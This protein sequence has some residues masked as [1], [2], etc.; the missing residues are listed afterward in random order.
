MQAV[1]YVGSVQVDPL[2]VVGH[3]QDLVLWG[4]VE[5]YRTDHLERAI[6][7]DRSLFEWGGNLQIRPIEELP[8]LRIVMQRKVEEPR[9]TL[10]ARRNSGVIRAVL[11]EVERRGP[12]GSRDLASTGSGRVTNYR[13]R[14]EAGLALYYLW[15][16][17]DL[18][19]AHR[20]RG[21]K[22][23]DLATRTYPRALREVP[24]EEAE[25]HL[26]FGTL[27]DL[28]LATA[29]EWLAYAHTRI[30]RS[31]LRL[32][33]KARVQRWR[34]DGRIL[35]TDVD[36]WK[37]R[38][39]YVAEAAPD[40][41]ALRD[42]RVPKSWTPCRTSTEEEVVFLSPLERVSGNGRAARLFD[43]EYVWEVYKPAKD[44]RWGY[45]TLP[46]L[47]GDR[48]TARIELKFDRGHQLL[49]VLGFWPEHRLSLRD[50]AFTSALGRALARM[51]DFHRAVEVD[52]KVLGTGAT[53]SRVDRAVRKYRASP[54][55]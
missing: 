7:R 30:G 24:V 15:L 27:R 1:R 4:R 44:R 28:G 20:Q 22:M 13:A 16:R 50:V 14:T 54:D 43:F 33:W 46:I 52:V 41:E 36:G 34:E 6:Y 17:G 23:F 53:W 39:F 10:F 12:L 18:L 55:A 51:A 38:R 21:E 11:A 40:L 37:G 3:S 45:Y 32:E 2:D 19:L 35:E 42:G 47:Y 9:W 5:G 49:R 29:S 31:T 25:Q 26:I 8:Y 48:L